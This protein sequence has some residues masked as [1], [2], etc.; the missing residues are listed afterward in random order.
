[1][2]EQGEG[3]GQPWLLTTSSPLP[4]LGPS[5]LFCP[6]LLIA[7]LATSFLLL[8]LLWLPW[9]ICFRGGL[10]ARMDWLPI[11]LWLYLLIA[12]TLF[13]SIFFLF[14]LFF[15]L[16]FLAFLQADKADIGA[17]VSEVEWRLI[18]QQPARPQ[19]WS[20]A[21]LCPLPQAD[22]HTTVRQDVEYPKGR[23]LGQPSDLRLQ[24][25]PVAHEAGLHSPSLCH[26]LSEPAKEEGS[27]VK[28][29]IS[30][31]RH[32]LHVFSGGPRAW[33]QTEPGKGLVIR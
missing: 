13:L 26:E 10:P 14:L 8:S 20:R 19:A 17:Q 18:S 24:L 33:A 28:E 4:S 16:S 31:S 3:Q 15:L 29:L 12:C 23:V 21:W 6:L 11:L 22:A 30:I 7:I 32:K 2:S 9:K 5:F 1:M 25:S 27:E